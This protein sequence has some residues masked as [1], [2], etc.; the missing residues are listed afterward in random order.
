MQNLNRGRVMTLIKV[1][2]DKGIDIRK[3]DRLIG[4]VIQF[5]GAHRF[6]E[7]LP[8]TGCAITAE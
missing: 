3:F 1:N 2:F 8:S 5:W 7:N 4:D 6:S